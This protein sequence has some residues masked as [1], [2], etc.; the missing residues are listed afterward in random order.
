M[1]WDV[2]FIF[3][4]KLKVS[5]TESISRDFNNMTCLRNN[6]CQEHYVTNGVVYC[7][8]FVIIN[9]THSKSSTFSVPKKGEYAKTKS[10]K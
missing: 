8:V 4:P 6:Q 3:I 9:L 1:N 5:F 10:R 2:A 7:Q